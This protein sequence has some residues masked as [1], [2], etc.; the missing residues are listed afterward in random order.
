MKN[1]LPKYLMLFLLYIWT[2]LSGAGVLVKAQS[3]D[4]L[5]SKAKAFGYS[6]KILEKKK[7]NKAK[8]F[9]QNPS[10]EN[11]ENLSNGDEIIR[12]ETMMVLNEILVFDERG[13]PIKGLKKEDFFIKEDGEPQ[14]ISTF[15]SGQSET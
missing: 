4:N 3:S 1:E 6:L 9:G 12:I 5:L 15:F 11:I 2:G 14:E 10:P 13:N 7:K 8:S